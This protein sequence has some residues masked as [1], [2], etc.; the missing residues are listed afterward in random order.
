VQVGSLADLEPGGAL[1]GAVSGRSALKKL[2]NRLEPG[3][4]EVEAAEL[5]LSP[6]Q[7]AELV[8]DACSECGFFTVGPVRTADGPILQVRCPRRECDATIRPTK[9]LLLDSEM[10][11]NAKRAA[12]LHELDLSAIV[13][14]A[15][16]HERQRGSTALDPVV[17][18]RIA[19]R[20]PP[21]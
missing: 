19:L 18:G 7:I 14:K 13:A 4:P 16:L 8:Q 6:S 12:A 9:E 21:T 2:L 20:L 17:V 1:I 11:E 15:L 10:A 5:H 3:T